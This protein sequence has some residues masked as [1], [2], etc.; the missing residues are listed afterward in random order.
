MLLTLASSARA[1]GA[2]RYATGSTPEAVAMCACVFL[3]KRRVPCALFRSL[4]LYSLSL[5]LSLSL[6]AFDRRHDI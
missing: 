5:S 6:P 2:G 3:N 1:D 4:T